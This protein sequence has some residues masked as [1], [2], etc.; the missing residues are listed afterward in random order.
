MTN[1]TELDLP[2]FDYSA[3][4]LTG[5][6]YHRRLTEVRKHGWLAQ[7]PLSYIVL[8]REAGEFFLRSRAT[9]TWS[10]R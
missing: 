3:A 7:G 10:P 6:L 4:D 2:V 9:V 5:E 1:V 8:D